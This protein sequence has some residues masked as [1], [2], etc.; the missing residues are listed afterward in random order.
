[1]STA[2]AQLKTVHSQFTEEVLQYL[3]LP[4]WQS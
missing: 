2:L 1:M 3:L 4:L